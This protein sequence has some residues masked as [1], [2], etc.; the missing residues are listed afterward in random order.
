MEH[1]VQSAQEEWQ[2]RV[3]ALLGGHG[4]AAEEQETLMTAKFNSMDFRN[5]QQHFPSSIHFRSS[6]QQDS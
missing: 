1:G 6:R 2:S 4:V 3:S 5:T